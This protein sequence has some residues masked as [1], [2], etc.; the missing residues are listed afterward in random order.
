[1]G[2]QLGGKGFACA[3]SAHEGD[4]AV[5]VDAGVEVVEGYQ[6]V[7]VLVDAQQY[8]VSVAQLVTD[9]RVAGGHAEGEHIAAVFFEEPRV[10]LAQRQRREKGGFLPEPAELQIHVLRDTE[11]AQLAHPPLQV[12]GVGRR[13]RHKDGC[14]VEIFP[15]GE[16]VLEEYPE[17]IAPAKSSKSVLVSLV[18][19]MRLRLSR[20]C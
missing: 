10:D 3:G 13:H 12:L 1:M 18:S 16:A 6:R 9:Q 8:T 11:L 2:D 7:V 14:V 17:R 15:V 19:L 5:F 20:I 4:A